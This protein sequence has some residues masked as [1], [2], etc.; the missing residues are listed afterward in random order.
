MDRLERSFEMVIARLQASD[1][2]RAKDDAAAATAVLHD[3]AQAEQAARTDLRGHPPQTT[4]A[5]M[6]TD[7]HGHLH[8]FGESRS[9]PQYRQVAGYGRAHEDNLCLAADD[10]DPRHLH[11]NPPL[12]HAGRDGVGGDDGG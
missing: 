7:H 8:R 1:A 4:L 5:T 6:Q 11:R 10:G 12:G 2:A 3:R 9:V